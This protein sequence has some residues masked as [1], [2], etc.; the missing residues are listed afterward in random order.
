MENSLFAPGQWI[1][2]PTRQKNDYA[3][4]VKDIAL[5][6][7]GT[8]LR[9]LISASFYYE[10]WI[11]G[12]FVARGPVHGDPQWC[13][14]D[15]LSFTPSAET[16]VL[17][18]TILV[19]H[20]DAYV[21][22][23]LPAPAGVV[24]LFEV[25]DVHIGTDAS[26]KC[27]PLEMWSQRVKKRGWAVGYPEDYDATQEPDGWDSKIFN[28][29]TTDSWPNAVPVENADAIWGNYQKRMTPYLKRS[30]I[31]PTHFDSFLAPGEGA[32]AINEVSSYCDEE[33]L[34]PIERKVLY[35]PENFQ[36]QLQQANA[37]TFDLGHEHIGFYDFD[38]EAPEGTII[39]VSGSELLHDGRPWI[40]HKGTH[41]SIRYRA[42]SGRQRFTSFGWSGFR[43][44]HFV[45]RGD[46]QKVKIHHIGCLERKVPLELKSTFTTSDKELQRIFDLCRRTL[47][48]GV[49]E[50][51]I[52]CPTREQAQYWG[53]AVFIAQSW[54]KGADERSY[55]E[56]YLACFLNVPFDENGQ[57]SS[58][59]PGNH[60]VLLDYS[61]I[62]LIGQR[63]F[64]EN[65]G[66]FYQP[67][68]TLNKAMQLK[69][70]YD[71][72]L[73]VDGLVAFDFEELKANNVINFIDHPGI[74]WHDFPH[75]GIDRQGVSGTLNLFYC[76]FL[77]VLAEIA[78]DLKAPQS[79]AIQKQAEQLAQTLRTKY[80]DGEVFYDAIDNG[81]RSDGTS[82][83]TNALAVYFDVVT[84]QEATT[85]MRSML[86][87]YDSVCRCSPYFH[88]FFLPAMRK[89]GL[90]EEAIELI[91]REWKM[92]LDRDATTTWEGFCG[93]EKDSLCHPWSTA[94]YLFFLESNERKDN[95]ES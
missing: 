85:V 74:G 63:F 41:Y 94:P 12:E 36:T 5:P 22:S 88:F 26:W 7:I 86:E 27:L 33:T 34:T 78:R 42:K 73:D 28:V 52:D 4:F 24:A 80:F 9:I 39:E 72:R 43:Y 30:L 81:V 15:E 91:K 61:L 54:W 21:H 77:Q 16:K 23:V 14:Y 1:W 62:P 8:P 82:W 57:I 71:D 50:H 18:A 76:G 92:M 45:V 75:R 58:V 60:T 56:W 31:E 20:E 70:W 51:L 35:T 40:V 69:C 90:E 59:Y 93:D 64:K 6:E 95:H 3:V 53:D 48:V 29:A 32:Q 10:L 46:A 55:L 67:Q 11:N 89:A 25:G 79:A 65:T 66:A 37:L 13:Q 84:G 17:C 47:E 87:R 38:I 2:T 68:A 44:L 19:H 83:Q 49:Q